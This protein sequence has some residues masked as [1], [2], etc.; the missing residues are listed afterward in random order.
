MDIFRETEDGTL[1]EMRET[2]DMIVTLFS[3]ESVDLGKNISGKK[4]FRSFRLDIK[5][6]FLTRS[7]DKSPDIFLIVSLHHR[8]IQSNTCVENF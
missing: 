2:G 8:E 4:S 3:N 6:N 1:Y 7:L 5:W